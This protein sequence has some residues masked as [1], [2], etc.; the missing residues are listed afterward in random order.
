MRT[1][2]I[3]LI[4]VLFLAVNLINAQDDQ[5]ILPKILLKNTTL[6]KNTTYIIDDN[7]TISNGSV[8]I[9]EEG[10][11]LKSKN[12]TEITFIIDSGSRVIAN[13]SYDSPITTL[14]EGEKDK[15]PSI[16]MKS[17]ISGNSQKITSRQYVYENINNPT[18]VV[19]TNTFIPSEISS[20]T[21]DF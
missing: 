15:Q 4:I 16:I 20:V 19:N 18:M 13:G 9:I 12:N 5:E 1:N 6:N 7:I 14:K 10:V 8:L 3:P 2:Y 21:P 11:Q 17:S